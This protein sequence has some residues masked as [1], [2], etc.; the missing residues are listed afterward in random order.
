MT[1]IAIMRNITQE[2][3]WGSKTFLPRLIGKTVGKGKPQAELWMGAHPKAPSKVIYNGEEKSIIDLV[4]ESPEQILGPSASRHFSG[5]F[6][7]LFKIIAIDRPLSIQA[8]PSKS[9]AIRGFS[10]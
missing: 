5:K 4:D 9:Q 10:R 3:S 6:P 1:Q 8:H 7:F 2:Y